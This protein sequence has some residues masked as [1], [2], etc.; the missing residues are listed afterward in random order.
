MFP[1][2]WFTLANEVEMLY[3]EDGQQ[4]PVSTMWGLWF[5]LPIVGSFVWYLKMQSSLNEF[6]AAHS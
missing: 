3:K 6:W 4:P 5:L 2:V 1:V